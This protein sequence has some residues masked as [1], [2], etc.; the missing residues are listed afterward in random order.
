MSKD[1]VERDSAVSVTAYTSHLKEFVSH[2]RGKGFSRQEMQRGCEGWKGMNLLGKAAL[3]GRKGTSR[4]N[5][6]FSEQNWASKKRKGCVESE[7]QREK[8]QQQEEKGEDE[9]WSGDSK[10]LKGRANENAFIAQ[11]K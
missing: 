8:K 11:K 4:G 6:T 2:G 7:N 1:A 3:T 10:R 5:C 9:E